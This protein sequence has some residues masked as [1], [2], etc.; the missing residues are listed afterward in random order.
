MFHCSSSFSLTVKLLF[1]L[2]HLLYFE[3]ICDIFVLLQCNISFSRMYPE[4]G[5]ASNNPAN[6]KRLIF[7]SGRVY[8]D[9][10]Q[11]RKEAGLE[12]KIAIARVEQVI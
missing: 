9:L 12:E 1:A 6:V 8:Y 2:Q 3:D 11:A 10:V 5:P 7:C 4:A